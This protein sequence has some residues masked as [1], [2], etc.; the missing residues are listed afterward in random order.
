MASIALDGVEQEIP[1]STRSCVSAGKPV[2]AVNLNLKEEAAMNEVHAQAKQDLADTETK[3]A[4]D[5]NFLATDECVADAGGA[6][7]WCRAPGWRCVHHRRSD[8]ASA[9]RALSHGREDVLMSALSVIYQNANTKRVHAPSASAK[10]ETHQKKASGAQ[11]ETRSR[12]ESVYVTHARTQ[13][14]C[15]P[16]CAPEKARPDRVRRR[17]SPR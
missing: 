4:S 10:Q 6:A 15:A 3:V 1:P 8:I 16:P 5:K 17:V 9:A 14:H 13:A 7:G 12:H 2:Q 11:S